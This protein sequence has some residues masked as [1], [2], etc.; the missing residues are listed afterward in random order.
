MTVVTDQMTYLKT[1]ALGV[2]VSTGSRAENVHQNGITHLLEHMAFK[3]TATRTAR[4]IAEEIEAVGGELN[5]STSIEH[6][7]YYARILAEDMPLAVDILAD[8]LQNSTF[9]A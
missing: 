1:A 6:N 2:W 7:N 4:G 5:A 8:I 9:D 3:G